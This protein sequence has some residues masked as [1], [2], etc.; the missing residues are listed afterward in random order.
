MNA[1]VVAI[2]PRRRKDGRLQSDPVR[3]RGLRSATAS[4]PLRARLDSTKFTKSLEKQ[5][6]LSLRAL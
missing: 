2:R 4:G 1:V 6:E 3:V 5:E